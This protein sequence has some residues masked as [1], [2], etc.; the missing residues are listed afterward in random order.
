[1]GLQDI[2]KDKQDQ[3]ED[4]EQQV[5]SK[6]KGV[7]Y[8]GNYGLVDKLARKI[9]RLG[10]DYFPVDDIQVE[11]LEYQVTQGRVTKEEVK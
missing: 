6:A 3:D 9:K 8:T 2:L 11:E 1:M 10:S 7:Y 4:Q 5:E